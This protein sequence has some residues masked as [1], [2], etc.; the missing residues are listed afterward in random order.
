MKKGM[1][2]L[3][4]LIALMSFSINNKSLHDFSVQTLEGKEFSFSSLK[5]KKVMIV[6]TASEC[7]YT[8]QYAELEGL[9]E[10]YKDKNFVIIGF[11][12]NDFGGQEPGTAAEIKTF[13]TK[14]YGVTFPLMEKV[15]IKGDNI[16]P[17]YKWLTHKSENGVEDA[18]VKWN[19][20]KF[21]IDENGKYVKHLGSG[22]TPMDD[23][24]TKWI[25]GK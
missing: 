19:F 20:N 3:I 1:L 25:E 17:V 12:C 7:G 22:V 8:P 11:P 15:V 24:I 6:N 2:S 18:N 10:K 23:E 5:G 4:A 9:Y 21:L 16:S 13:C 14:N